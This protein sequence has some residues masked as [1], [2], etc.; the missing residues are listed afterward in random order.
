MFID[1]NEVSKIQLGGYDL[2]KYAQDPSRGLKWY[3]LTSLM[4]WQVPFHSVTMGT[5]KFSPSVNV[6]MADSGTS[7]NMIPD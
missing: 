7:L 4:Y 3:N 5:H 6:M 2:Q 1:Q